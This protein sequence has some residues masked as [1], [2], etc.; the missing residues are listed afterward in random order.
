MKHITV[1]IPDDKY[2]FFL[3]LINNLGFLSKPK[4]DDQ[5]ENEN[6]LFDSLQ[7]GFKELELAK[8]GKLETRSLKDF[9][10]EV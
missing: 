8:E 10:D 7:Q 1:D 3:E 4:N 6:S 2:M 9:L 5:A